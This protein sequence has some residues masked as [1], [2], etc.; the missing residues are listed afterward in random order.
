MAG[1]NYY[2]TLGVEKT[3]SEDELKKGTPPGHQH[4]HALYILVAALGTV[5]CI[6]AAAQRLAWGRL[7]RAGMVHCNASL[8]AMWGGILIIVASQVH[9]IT[10]ALSKI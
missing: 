4:T 5:C 7:G 8:L 2:A 10:C 6:T 9:P 1:K 3:A